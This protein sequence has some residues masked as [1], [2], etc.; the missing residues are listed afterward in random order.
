MNKLALTEI[1]NTAAREVIRR[2]RNRNIHT[3]KPNNSMNEFGKHIPDGGTVNEELF[4]KSLVGMLR[5]LSPPTFKEVTTMLLRYWNINIPQEDYIGT[6]L[7]SKYDFSP[8]EL[9]QILSD[10]HTIT[11]PKRDL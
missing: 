1:I 8:E 11:K 10:V 4:K 5:E 2:V 7:H 3:V 6:I 9:Y